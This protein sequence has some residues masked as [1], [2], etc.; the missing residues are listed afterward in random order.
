MPLI[1]YVEWIASTTAR[2]SNSPV[3]PNSL[4]NAVHRAR[5][6]AR[7]R[8]ATL[9]AL[10]GACIAK[11]AIVH[12]NGG[13]SLTG[14][15]Q[16]FSCLGNNLGLPKPLFI[17]DASD[18]HLQPN[19]PGVNFGINSVVASAFDLDGRPRVPEGFVDIGAYESL[20]NPVSWQWILARLG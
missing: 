19:S 9:I 20:P 1:H 2:P 8:L 3:H 18:F 13:D 6:A 4:L 17:N 15:V 10:I 7:H 16:V 11:S 14:S 12:N 5:P